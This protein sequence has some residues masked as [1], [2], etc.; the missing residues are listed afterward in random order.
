MLSAKQSTSAAIGFLQH[1]RDQGRSPATCTQADVDDWLADGPTTRSL[2]RTFVRWASAHHHLPPLDFPYRLARTEP[3]ITQQQRLEHISRLLDPDTDLTA[4]ER[5][6][7]LLLLL[8]GQPLTRIAGM[9]LQQLNLSGQAVTILITNDK[10]TIPAPFDEIF[11]QH[12]AELPHQTTSVHTDNEWLFPGRR[13]GMHLHQ[14]SLMGKLR[15]AGIDLRGARN[16]ALRA[17]VL[18]LPAP[19]IADALDY[20]YQVT[21]KHRRNAGTTFIDYVARRPTPL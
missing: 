18:E 21:D 7:S 13:P 1:L 3:I 16:A 11:R 6:A 10:L 8:Y 20:S 17:L 5:A 19:V 12:V 2:A 4:D 15:R 9:R 14:N